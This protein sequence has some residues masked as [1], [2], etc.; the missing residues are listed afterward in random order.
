MFVARE[1]IE[2]H[3]W[4]IL[5]LDF[6]GFFPHTQYLSIHQIYYVHSSLELGATWLVS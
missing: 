5:V 3:L 6:V 4:K 2:K 1:K